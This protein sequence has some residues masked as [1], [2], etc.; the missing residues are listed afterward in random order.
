[1]GKINTIYNT[2]NNFDAS[3]NFINNVHGEVGR[4]LSLDS[5]T[6]PSRKKGDEL[7]T[8]RKIGN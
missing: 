1:V 3:L 5:Y 6:R 4:N 7:L 2:N 8:N